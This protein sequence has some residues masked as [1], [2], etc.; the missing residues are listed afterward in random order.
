[1][2]NDIIKRQPVDPEA[3]GAEKPVEAPPAEAVAQPSVTAEASAAPVVDAVKTQDATNV[4]VDPAT[5][6][7][8]P[9][10]KPKKK[11]K[12]GET[13]SQPDQ[14]K[15]PAGP[16]LAIGAAIFVCLILVGLVVYS[17]ISN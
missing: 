11:D 2:Q 1:M 6:E 14:P 3:R 16:G 12:A 17:Q 13:A 8:K 10:D 4:Q 7:I 5:D 15:P 9:N